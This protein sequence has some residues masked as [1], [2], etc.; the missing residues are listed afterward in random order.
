MAIT[1]DVPEVAEK[2]IEL[3][4]RVRFGEEVVIAEAGVPIARLVAIGQS[5][6]PKAIAEHSSGR[7]PGQDKGKVTIAPDFNDPLSPDLLNDFL[8]SSDFQQ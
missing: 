7:I 3:L 2:I 8:G 6:A 1:V 4:N 5:P